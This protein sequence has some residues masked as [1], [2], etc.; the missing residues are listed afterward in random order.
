LIEAGHNEVLA[1][2]LPTVIRDAA[3]QALIWNNLPVAVDPD[4]DAA[5]VTL[6]RQH[7]VFRQGERPLDPTLAALLAESACA[8]PLLGPGA[9]GEV[10]RVEFFKDHYRVGKETVA[11][12]IPPEVL[13]RT[14]TKAL[15]IAHRALLN[16]VPEKVRSRVAG[17][18]SVKLAGRA[19]G[20]ANGLS[21]LYADGSTGRRTL[22]T[23]AWTLALAALALGVGVALGVVQPGG[24]QGLFW[25]LL[26]VPVVGLVL[27]GEFFGAGWY[28][29]VR[30]AL[31]IGVGVL[32]IWKAA[33]L[34][35]SLWAHLGG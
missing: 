11:G 6:D 9:L 10:D 3:A 35:K 21:G 20:V 30:L 7:L 23:V 28:A 26:A 2:D 19:I 33:E 1:D 22:L 25:T 24:A 34:I 15:A 12:H 18:G 4:A 8:A 17:L 14:V 5:P 29:A 27:W 32:A 13:A 16:S 31:G